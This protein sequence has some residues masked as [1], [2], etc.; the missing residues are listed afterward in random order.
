MKRCSKCDKSDHRHCKRGD[1]ECP[2]QEQ[3]EESYKA[4]LD[5][6]IR[7]KTQDKF[8]ENMNKK[9]KSLNVKPP[10]KNRQ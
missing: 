8:F 9:W 10:N 6:I 5:E 4:K 3:W 2:C 1:C 7:D